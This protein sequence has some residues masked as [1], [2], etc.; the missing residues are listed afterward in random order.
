MRITISKRLLLIVVALVAIAAAVI[1][2]LVVTSGGTSGGSPNTRPEVTAKQVRQLALNDSKST[3]TTKLGGEG[4]HG[5]YRET[6]G[7][8]T[9]YRDCWYYS[10]VGPEKTGTTKDFVACFE[11]GKLVTYVGPFR[12]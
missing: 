4:E 3:M 5:R 10:P 11:A 9:E 2:G 8:F 7:N 12:Y 6:T 1:V